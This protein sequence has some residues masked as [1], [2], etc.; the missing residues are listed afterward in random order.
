MHICKSWD[1]IWQEAVLRLNSIGH[2]LFSGEY[3]CHDIMTAA[4]AAFGSDFKLYC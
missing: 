4:M 3:N 2:S 1:L